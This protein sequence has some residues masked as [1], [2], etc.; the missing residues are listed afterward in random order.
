MILHWRDQRLP[1]IFRGYQKLLEA[2]KS[3]V[4]DSNHPGV[5]RDVVCDVFM[6]SAKLTELAEAYSRLAAPR[7]APRRLLVRP[8][9]GSL[10]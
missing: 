3:I 2:T 4:G 9:M 7:E 10:S 1:K 6:G 8:R 5:V